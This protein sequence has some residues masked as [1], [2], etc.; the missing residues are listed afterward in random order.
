MNQ[1]MNGTR[2][3]K[4]QSIEKIPLT[5]CSSFHFYAS[6][7][8]ETETP[9]NIVLI[10]SNLVLAYKILNGILQYDMKQLLTDGFNKTPRDD[11]VITN[12][13]QHIYKVEKNS[14]HLIRSERRNT[15]TAID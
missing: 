5:F 7:S 11:D 1:H 8:D 6:N 4:F 12:F 15:L 13:T 3:K 2:A 14:T 10:A 9:Y